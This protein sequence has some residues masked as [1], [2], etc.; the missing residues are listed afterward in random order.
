MKSNNSREC[1]EERIIHIELNA[2]QFNLKID[3]LLLSRTFL[4]VDIAYKATE[5]HC[6][7]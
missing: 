3:F 4:P 7:S 6:F 1:C 5:N 2:H